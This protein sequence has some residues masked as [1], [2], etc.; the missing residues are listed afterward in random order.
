MV[1][2]P[3]EIKPIDNSGTIPVFSKKETAKALSGTFGKIKTSRPGFEG[4][5]F[6]HLYL[7]AYCSFI[8]KGGLVETNIFE[9]ILRDN[10]IDLQCESC[11]FFN[12]S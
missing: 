12:N 11:H 5:D 4:Y 8:R 6:G 1:E 9:E 3:C 10:Q 7:N 2:R